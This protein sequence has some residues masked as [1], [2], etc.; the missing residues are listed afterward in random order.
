MANQCDTCG[1]SLDALQ[2]GFF[3][4]TLTCIDCVNNARIASMLKALPDEQDE[5]AAEAWACLPESTQSFLSSVR[6]QFRKKGTLS[7]KTYQVLERIYKEQ[8]GH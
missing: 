4:P 7:E 5:W 8:H 6:K 3:S 1:K 2:P